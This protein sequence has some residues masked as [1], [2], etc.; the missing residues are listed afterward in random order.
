[1]STLY[2]EACRLIDWPQFFSSKIYGLF[3]VYLGKNS[4]PYEVTQHVVNAR[5]FPPFSKKIF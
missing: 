4:A 2:R 3:A 1:M 5:L